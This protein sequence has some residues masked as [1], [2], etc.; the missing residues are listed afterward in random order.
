MKHQYSLGDSELCV[1]YT[2]MNACM[3]VLQTLHKPFPFLIWYVVCVNSA[4]VL[5]LCIRLSK[6]RTRVDLRWKTPE[7]WALTSEHTMGVIE[8]TANFTAQRAERYVSV[9]D[10][11][12][13]GQLF[14]LWQ[15]CTHPAFSFYFFKISF[16]QRQKNL[17]T[18]RHFT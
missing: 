16:V 12:P 6:L 15:T 1:T 3:C 11:L 2:R 8:V 10:D 17:S 5:W 9:F 18:I 4:A 13:E 7:R 14:T